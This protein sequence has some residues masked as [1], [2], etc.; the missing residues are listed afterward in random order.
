ME[1][2]I[3]ACTTVDDLKTLFTWTEDAEGNIT[4][5]LVRISQRYYK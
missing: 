1:T 4:R 2:Q 3:N 5:P